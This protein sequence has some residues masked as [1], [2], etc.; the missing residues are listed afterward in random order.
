MS[1]PFYAYSAITDRPPLRMP[2]GER[3]AVWAGLNIEH[4]EYGKPALS[5]AQFTAG[6]TPDPLNHGWRDYGPRV[7]IWRLV[8]MFDHLDIQ[9]TAIVN[10]DVVEQYPAIVRAGIERG[11]DWVAH[12]KN[13]STWQTGM[14][15]AEEKAY[16]GAVTDSIE[17]ATGK[18]PKGWLGPALTASAATN[19]LLAEHGYLYNLDWGVDDEPFPLTVSA[20]SLISVPYSTELNDIPFSVLQ[21]QPAAAFGQALIDQFDQLYAEGA[22]RPRVLGFGVHPFLSGQ[23][24]RLRYLVEA[25]Q[26][27][28]KHEGVWFAT[29]D[30]IA[31]WYRDGA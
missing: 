23:P 10:S 9:P 16:I 1:N 24:Y 4:Y 17:F 30:E 3:I 15:P 14:A 8:D 21:G 20:G 19:D 11:W 22:S 6:L 7:G 12:G 31:T 2:R 25:L 13:N 26:H 5:L 27:M 28:A 29:A 18:R